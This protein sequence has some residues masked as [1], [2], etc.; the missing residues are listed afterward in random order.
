MYSIMDGERYIFFLLPQWN[1]YKPYNINQKDKLEINRKRTFFSAKYAYEWKLSVCMCEDGEQ[2]VEMARKGGRSKHAHNVQED[3]QRSLPDHTSNAG[4]KTT[5][6][7]Y[8][9]VCTLTKLCS[10]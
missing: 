3:T 4:K 9:L 10:T 8:T 2:K 5:R 6:Q 7:F 1:E